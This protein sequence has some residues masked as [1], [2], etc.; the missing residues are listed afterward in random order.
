MKLPHQLRVCRPLYLSWTIM[1]ALPPSGR[2]LLRI[3]GHRG[4]PLHLRSDSAL[5]LLEKGAILSH[6]LVHR[7]CGLPNSDQSPALRSHAGMVSFCVPFRNLRLLSFLEILGRCLPLRR[8]EPPPSFSAQS[9]VSTKN[10]FSSQIG[11]TS[12]LHR[13]RPC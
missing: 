1:I 9:S 11:R 3:P 7:T 8:G 12:C 2:L 10:C 13:E 6:P 4:I 5:Q